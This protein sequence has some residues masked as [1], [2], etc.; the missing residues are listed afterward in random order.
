M[1][2]APCCEK[3]G[4]KKG[5]W[6]A[7]EDEILAKYIAAN[8]EGSWRSLPKNA[9]LLRCGKSCR[10]RWINYLRSDLKRGNITKEEEAVI[11]K[12]H[13]TLGN[14]WS[15]I[16][17]HLPGRTDNE[18]KNYWNSH[19]SRRID[20]FR[21]LGLD[22][23]DAAILDL[24]ML[25][26][27]GKRRGGRTSRSVARK[28]AIG[29]GT[30][31]RGRQQQQQQ[32]QGVVV[33]PPASLVQSDHSV[34]LDP[35]QNQASSVTNEGLVDA[36]EEM[37]S[38]LVCCTSPMDGRL[39]DTHAPMEHLL[40]GPTEEE[41][42]AGWGW[43]REG[44]SGVMSSS[45]EGGGGVPVTGGQEEGGAATGLGVVESGPELVTKGEEEVGS[46][47]S[48]A[49]EK[50]LDWDL[51][52]MEAKLWDEAGEMWWHSEH[53]DLGMHG[54]DDGGYQEEEPLDS[55]L[56]FSGASLGDITALGW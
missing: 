17:G 33:S 1:G 51:E 19:L 29:G 26:G 24:S 22:G 14:R 7:E 46:S 2:R 18:I 32:Q 36:N 40:F 21:R 44:D 43:S 6:T 45:E 28:F 38:E 4:L 39:W 31:G 47:S 15:L 52:A 27:A 10:L 42:M 5:R 8:G 55:W 12:L 56:I 35:D 49:E 13:A 53:Q 37:A 9:G 54:L 20:S 3:V 16:A 23:G 11:I 30:V 48:L 41:S 25:P 34:V 50:L